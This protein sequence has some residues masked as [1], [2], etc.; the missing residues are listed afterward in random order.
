MPPTP[1]RQDTRFD[2]PRE[3]SALIED[4]VKTHRLRTPTPEELSSEAGRIRYAIEL[5]KAELVERLR[6]RQERAGG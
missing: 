4:L 2:V 5:G 3:S 1:D 6:K